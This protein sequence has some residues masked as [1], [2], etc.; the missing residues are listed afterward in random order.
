MRVE[1]ELE[2]NLSTK[3]IMK[4]LNEKIEADNNKKYKR[5]RAVTKIMSI[6]VAGVICL[7]SVKLVDILTN[8]KK[9]TINNE[10]V[11]NI[12][13]TQVSNSSYV[14]D[15][16]TMKVYASDDEGQFI[17]IENGNKVL[18]DKLGEMTNWARLG[19]TT[20]VMIRLP[21]VCE[22]EDIAKVKYEFDDKTTV[23]LS[24]YEFPDEIAN[25]TVE[26]LKKDIVEQIA[27]LKKDIAEQIIND[28]NSKWNNYCYSNNLL[29][30]ETLNKETGKYYT[31]Q[32]LDNVYEVDY[33]KQDIK[34]MNFL[35]QDYGDITKRDE[36]GVMDMNKML[37]SQVLRVTVTKNDGS[38]ATKSYK[39]EAVGDMNKEMSAIRIYELQE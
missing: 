27:D 1:K 14:S 10:N 36:N 4:S 25:L 32:K 8:N 30:R 11:E 31:Y 2:L 22:G 37:E 33:D 16:F 20:N 38:T 3:N 19:N 7:T 6:A 21:I 28:N 39:F 24:Y 17:K 13:A 23:F 34:G 12:S 18:I 5:K 15:M 29:P 26:D 35:I 9:N